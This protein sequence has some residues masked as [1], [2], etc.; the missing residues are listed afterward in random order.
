MQW[1]AIMTKVIPWHLFESSCRGLFCDNCAN[2]ENNKQHSCA[3]YTIHETSLHIH[4]PCVEYT[5]HR[6]I[7]HRQK[8]M[9]QLYF[10]TMYGIHRHPSLISNL[11]CICCLVLNLNV[12]IFQTILN[13]LCLVCVFQYQMIAYLKC[14]LDF[15]RFALLTSFTFF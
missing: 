7:Q 1:C 2:T 6:A 8:T 11:I 3:M 12:C 5:G 14:I 9:W 4:L 10:Q 13:S 15:T